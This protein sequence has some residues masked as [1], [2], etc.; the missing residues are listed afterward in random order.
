MTEY[1]K[2][3]SYKVVFFDMDG[4]L[5][6]SEPLHDKV[7]D[8][9]LA[10]MG[11]RAEAGIRRQFVGASSE[12]LW[13][14]MKQ[15]YNLTPE[16]NDLIDLQWKTIIK[17]IQ[18]GGIIESQGLTE[19]LKYLKKH[20]IKTAV[21]SSSR[22]DFIEAVIDCL[23]IREY[24]DYVVDGFQVMNGKPAP[25]I[26]LLAAEQGR[27]MPEECLVVEDSTNGVNSGIN[28]GMTVIGYDNPT[29][30]GQDISKA[31]Y[32]VKCLS[33]IIELFEN[34]NKNA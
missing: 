5:L 23:D 22:R 2:L 14:A 13:V 21:V 25:D 26:Y 15:R 24:L 3:Q 31:H 28:A 9:I 29:S 10:D 6:D 19:L 12:S 8:H 20:N 34:K 27:F 18:S 30:E 16:I 33:E 32:I 4:V 11:V 1:N 17:L 7:L